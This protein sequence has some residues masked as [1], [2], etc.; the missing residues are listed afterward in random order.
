ME[1]QDFHSSITANVDAKRAFESI[2]RVSEW[3][4]KNFEGN[5]QKPGDV[6]TVHFGETFVTF[7][8]VEVV[9]DKIFTW[10]V[11]DCHLHWLADKKEWKD[12]KIKWEVSTHDHATQID[13]THIGLVPEIECY[14]NC[15]KG[16]SFYVK[17]SLFKLITEG[18]GLPD[19]PRSSRN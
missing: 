5:S 19:V 6:F 4:A 7:K 18:K 16:W 11:I 15:T 17:E 2:S 10:Q 14:D 13:F 3:W 8:V 12:T 1:K 9:A